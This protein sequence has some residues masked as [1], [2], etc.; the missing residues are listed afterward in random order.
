M[1]A[2]IADANGRIADLSNRMT[3]VEPSCR[4]VFPDLNAPF[5]PSTFVV[6]PLATQH[7]CFQLRP[8]VFDGFTSWAAFRLQFESVAVASGWSL[9]DQASV[10]VAQLR[11]PASYVLEY[12]PQHTR[13]DY[14]S[15]MRAM[16][17]RFGA[18]RFQQTHFA[19]L[20]R[21]RQQGVTLEDLANH[22]ERLTHKALAGSPNATKD[23]IGTGA[24]VD[25]LESPNV[26]RFVRLAQPMI[27]RAPLGLALEASAVESPAAQ[28]V[29][30]SS[31][32][33]NFRLPYGGFRQRPLRLGCYLC[34]APGHYA[35]DLDRRAGS[36]SSRTGNASAG[37]RGMEPA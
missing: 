24:F 15:L 20:K 12:L 7:Q 28:Q 26:Q 6:P 2:W 22:V 31:S 17:D 37:R 8:P 27:V 29:E 13:H 21:V 25:A 3:V 4:P 14:P 19:E 16:N 35:R 32:T 11:P 34:G 18:A 9:T 1:T 10:L 33:S 23:L 36:L 30:S 5:V